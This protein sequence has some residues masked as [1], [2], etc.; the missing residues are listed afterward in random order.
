[1]LGSLAM[2]SQGEAAFTQTPGRVALLAGQPR[3]S[4]PVHPAGRGVGGVMGE[5]QEGDNA[6]I[7]AS[8][9][10]EIMMAEIS[11]LKLALAQR[12]TI[13]PEVRFFREAWGWGKCACV[14]GIADGMEMN[15]V[16]NPHLSRPFL[17]SA[18]WGWAGPAGWTRGS[19]NV[20]FSARGWI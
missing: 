20:W 4:Q 19:A 9:T 13:A 3:V 10:L 11:S 14:H 2:P 16:G 6:R 7:L 15:S 8:S 18:G 12:G 17:G 5:L 1:V